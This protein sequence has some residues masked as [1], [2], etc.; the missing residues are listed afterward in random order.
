M[1]H[2]ADAVR[3]DATAA[4]GHSPD[5]AVSCSALATMSKANSPA[6]RTAGMT[7]ESRDEL[8]R[9]PYDRYELGVDGDGTV[10]F[11]SPRADRIVAVATDG[12]IETTIDL[13][14]HDHAEKVYSGLY[15]LTND[16]ED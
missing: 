15:E 9:L 12:S 16:P 14:D 8:E 10:H 3:N 5:D 4:R 1:E 13:A 7:V 2:G 11:H 6:A